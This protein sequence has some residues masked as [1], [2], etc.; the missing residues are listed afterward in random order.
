MAR[1]RSAATK[2]IRAIRKSL[3]AIDRALRQ[4]APM[5]KPAAVPKASAPRR[6]M[7]ITRKRRAALKQQGQYMG[8]MRN[9]SA[10]KKAQVKAV[11]ERKGMAAAIVLARNLGGSS[12]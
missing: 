1:R 2:H 7:K 9:L 11:K 5:L 8:Y 12:R 10:R 3:T 6:K 4:L